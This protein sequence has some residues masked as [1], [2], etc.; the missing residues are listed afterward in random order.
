MFKFCFKRHK[1]TTPL[2]DMDARCAME[3]YDACRRDDLEKAKELLPQMTVNQINYQHPS[4]GENTSLH[5]AARHNNQNI[6]KLLLE[7]NVDRRLRNSN[8]QTALD[9][10]TTNETRQL[11]ECRA[12]IESSKCESCT[13]IDDKTFYEWEL[14]DSEALQLASRFRRELKPCATLKQQ[15]HLTYIIHKG[16]LPRYLSTIKSDKE[17]EEIRSKFEPALNNKNPNCIVQYFTEEQKFSYLLSRDMARNVLH[18]MKH[19]CS[20]FSC[21]CLYTTKD[22]T[23]AMA[24][25]LSHWPTFITYSGNKL[26]RGVF[27]K[28]TDLAHY[29]ANKHIIVTTFLPTSK[30]I[31]VAR[32]F[33]GYNVDSQ[34][35]DQYEEGKASFLF[36]YTMKNCICRTAI[37]LGELS[38]RPHEN[39]VLI[40]PY[41]TFL[42]TN[43]TTYQLIPL[44]RR[45]EI[46]LEQCV[47]QELP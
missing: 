32:Q 42:I 1:V 35:L 21:I 6:I 11:F 33:S 22:G 34:R 3:L 12:E 24:S 43:I 41:S 31:T 30:D 47:D 5:E 20:E 44:G 9:L 28:E 7:R 37:E 19:G 17:V 15:K 45:I 38:A 2:A 14:I 40:L 10:C 18:D 23:K 25:I 27:M 4:A 13:L 36:T 46:E 29:T 8:G 26:Y 16:Y 39:E